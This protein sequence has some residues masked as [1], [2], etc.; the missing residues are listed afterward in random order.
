MKMA[1]L[2]SITNDPQKGPEMRDDIHK[3]ADVTTT[4]QNLVNTRR[5]LD[6]EEIFSLRRTL[7]ILS[8]MHDDAVARQI[9]DLQDAVRELN[10][11]TDL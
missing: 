9:E 5:K 1:S 6:G 7:R 3:L 8:D 4:L 10:P 2:T 11:G